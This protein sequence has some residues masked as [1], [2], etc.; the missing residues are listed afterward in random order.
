MAAA[1]V[2]ATVPTRARGHW[3]PVG[4]ALWRRGVR[5]CTRR[6]PL[7]F[8]TVAARSKVR[9]LQPAVVNVVSVARGGEA[10]HPRVLCACTECSVQLLRSVSPWSAG[11]GVE[12]SIHTAMVKLIETAQRFVY[13]ENQYFISS[14]PDNGVQNNVVA[15]LLARIV[16]AIDTG[17]VYGPRC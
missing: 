13:I 12:K 10:T 4:M 9:H 8:K 5:R 11:V 3:V 1:V 2:L 14:T 7:L 17:Y 6:W 16:R 15:T